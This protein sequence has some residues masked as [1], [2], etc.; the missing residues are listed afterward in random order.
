MTLSQA[1]KKL[2]FFCLKSF[3]SVIFCFKFLATF[4]Q[5]SFFFCKSRNFITDSHVFQFLFFSL[6]F[7][8]PAIFSTIV[9]TFQNRFI[10]LGKSILCSVSI[11]AT[12]CSV[13][14]IF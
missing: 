1:V 3:N 4:F 2:Y 7:N 5:F 12:I 8:F 14:S 9:K 11:Y 6:T 10:F 13:S